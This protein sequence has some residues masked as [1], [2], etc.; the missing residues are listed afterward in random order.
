[1]VRF[2]HY[3]I[4]IDTVDLLIT[5]LQLQLFIADKK[6]KIVSSAYYRSNKNH[7]GF[8]NKALSKAILLQFLSKH[9]STWTVVITSGNG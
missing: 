1:M 8:M 9:I 2:N 7:C 6:R 5:Q 3:S 4:F